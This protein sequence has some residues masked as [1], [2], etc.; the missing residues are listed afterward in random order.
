MDNQDD[1]SIFGR[2]VIAENDE[3]NT[4]LYI[5]IPGAKEDSQKLRIGMVKEFIGINYFAPSP[6]TDV[7]FGRR[8]SVRLS[9][10]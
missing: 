2:Q 3:G 9:T 1:I 8:H 6:L 7:A 4:F 5:I 10:S